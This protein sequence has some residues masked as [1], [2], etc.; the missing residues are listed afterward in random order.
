MA[1]SHTTGDTLGLNS[2][3][4]IF[5]PFP[6]NP[7]HGVPAYSKSVPYKLPMRVGRRTKY[8]PRLPTESADPLSLIGNET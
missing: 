7:H 5:N 8:D 4:Q 3:S 1:I 2:S 6:A